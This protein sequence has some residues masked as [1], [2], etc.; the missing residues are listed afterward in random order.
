VDTP[1]QE[2]TAPAPEAGSS[3]QDRLANILGSEVEGYE[4][5]AE[6]PQGQP[7]AEAGSSEEA[8]ESSEPAPTEEAAPAEDK[9][10]DANWEEVE[11]ETG[12]KHKIP[13]SLKARFMADKDYR[14]KTMALAEERKAHEAVKQATQ[15]AYQ[16]ATVL[17]DIVSGIKG[18]EAELQRLGQIDLAALEQTDLLEAMN[19][20]Q[21]IQELLWQ[22]QQFYGQFEQAQHQIGRAQE[23]E[24]AELVAR[25]EPLVREK[26]KDWGPEK[27]KAIQS[28]LVKDWGFTQQELVGSPALADARVV[29]ILDKAAAWDRLQASKPATQ[30]RVTNAP[31][32]AKPGN[33]VPAEF[34][35]QANYNKALA[36]VRKSGGETEDI[37]AALKARRRG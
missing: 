37:V 19:K 31:P 10:A 15:A 23:A 21:R 20:R 13:A 26:I 14:Q 7:D 9:P 1:E 3:L 4:P 27:A 6:E 18:T 29:A 5:K 32:V 17:G 24:Y 22:R 25:N 2:S 34:Q 35:Q 36:Q 8:T 16:A 12:T 33:K 11:D 28:S 30:N